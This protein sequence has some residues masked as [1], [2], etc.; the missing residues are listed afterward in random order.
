[1]IMRSAILAST[2]AVLLLAFSPPP[3]AGQ[4]SLPP[5]AASA[6]AIQRTGPGA[7]PERGAGASSKHAEPAKRAR[8]RPMR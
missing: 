2:G 7:G 8:D 5:V 6:A 3:A 1:M 4:N